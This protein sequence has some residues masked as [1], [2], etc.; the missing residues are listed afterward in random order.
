MNLLLFVLAAYGLTQ[1]TVYGRIFDRIRPSHHFFH[2]PMCV[3]WWI[4]LFLWAI[5]GFTELFTFDYS[6]ATAFLLACISSGT[7]YMLGMTFNDDGVN[8]KIRGDK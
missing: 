5:N 6:I 2:C 7:S 1:I 4:G 3:G 8:F